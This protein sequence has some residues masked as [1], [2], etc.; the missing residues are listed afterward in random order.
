MPGIPTGPRRSRLLSSFGASPLRSSRR[1]PKACDDSQSWQLDAADSNPTL[2]SGG[3]VGPDASTVIDDLL[4]LTWPDPDLSSH[5]YRA[6]SETP[7]SWPIP[8]YNYS[9]PYMGYPWQL[10]YAQSNRQT[11]ATLVSLIWPQ[12]EIPGWYGSLYG[13]TGAFSQVCFYWPALMY[14]DN[15]Q[16]VTVAS[17]GR[18]RLNG[19]V[20]AWE[21]KCDLFPQYHHGD[22]VWHTG[23]GPTQTSP[24]TLATFNFRYWAT[25]FEFIRNYQPSVFL[26]D[27]HASPIDTT[28]AF[29]YPGSETGFSPTFDN[30]YGAMLFHCFEDKSAWQ[31]RTGFTLG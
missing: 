31:T 23:F 25:N 6:Y 9:G 27:F 20:S 29:N 26:R 4:D 1:F 16:N 14:D 3:I 13:S 28:S 24:Y 2:G 18:Y 21:A 12:S 15:Y 19:D 17:R 5:P 22:G 7:T 30:G 10:I 8:D 11:F